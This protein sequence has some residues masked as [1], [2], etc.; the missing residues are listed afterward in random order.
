MTRMQVTMRDGSSVRVTQRRQTARVVSRGRE[1]VRIRQTSGGGGR[2]YEGEYEVIPI[3][4]ADQ[5]LA[6]SGLVMRDDVTVREIPVEKVSNPSGGYT[7]TIGG[8]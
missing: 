6:T 5:V 7:A 3:L 4:Y 8:Y 1:T 2:P